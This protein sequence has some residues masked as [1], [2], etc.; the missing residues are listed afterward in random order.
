[1]KN[2]KKFIIEKLQNKKKEY[3][4]TIISY[5]NKKTNYT[6]AEYNEQFIVIKNGKK[7]ESLLYLM[8]NLSNNNEKKAIRFNFDENKLYS[9]DMWEKFIFNLE[10]GPIYN[11][12]S[13]EMKVPNSIIEVLDDIVNFVEGNFS[14][15][16]NITNDDDDVEKSPD[17]KVKSKINDFDNLELDIFEIV[18]ANVIQMIF[19]KNARALIV[20]GLGGLGKTYDVRSTLSEFNKKYHYFKGNTTSAGLY[21]LLFRYRNELIVLDDMDDALI[22]ASSGDILK[23]VLDTGEERIVS[24]KI[25][26]YY[27]PDDKTDD[28]IQ[29]IYLKTGKLPNQFDFTGKIIFITNLTEK[30][31][32]PVIFTRVVHVDVHLTQHEIIQRIRKIMPSMLPDISLDMK[33]ETLDIMINLLNTYVEKAPLNLRSFYHCLNFRVS[34]DFN[35]N[36]EKLWKILVKNFLVRKTKLTEI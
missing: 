11:K 28:E 31:V 27:Y 5:L 36:G 3:I 12:P 30:D 20:S 6:Y 29:N 4:N 34:N 7:Y 14:V 17:E 32:D 15:K 33:Y 9:I 21:E 25:K 24:R 18:K 35:L 16:E 22:D 2:Y 1:M 13:F 10:D 26:G 23:A 8:I 19:N